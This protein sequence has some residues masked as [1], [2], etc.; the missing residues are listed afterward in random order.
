M[1]DE[2]AKK[3][4]AAHVGRALLRGVEAAGPLL[5]LVLVVVVFAIADYFR[6]G[7]D[8]FLTLF[9]ARSLLVR[10]AMIA[11]PALGMTAVIIAGGVDLSAGTA[12]VLSGASIALTLRDF[13][14][15]WAPTVAVCLGLGVGLLAGLINGALVS[16]LRV[17]PFIV[18]LGTMTIYLGVTKLLSSNTS[19]RPPRDLVPNWIP[20]LMRPIP[21][22]EWVIRGVIPNVAPGVWAALVLALV[23]A[24]ILRRTVFGRYVFALGSNEAT[25]RL[26]GVN[27]PVVKTAV[28]A[29]SGLFIGVGGLY[30]FA[31]LV[32]T[33]PADGVGRELEIIAAVVI[34][35]GSL[36][37]GRGSVLGTIGGA[38]VMVVLQ[39]GCTM[40]GLADYYQDMLIGAIIIVAVALD[41]LRQRRAER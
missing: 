9:N 28:Y 31:R 14:S 12:M 2:N 36:N 38:G 22:H 16:A 5:A 40:M 27:V 35:G 18:T 26:C 33:A 1:S 25:A 10:T 8:T 21:E 11:V 4:P 3:K 19:V 30:Y 7:N 17:A 24:F 29:L 15:A 23:M 32:A 37:G 41:Q 34:G 6:P 20:A 39:N 13:D